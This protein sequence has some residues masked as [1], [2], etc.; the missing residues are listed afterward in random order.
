VKFTRT[1]I[2]YALEK[3]PGFLDISINDIEELLTI[4]EK[5]SHSEDWQST[6]KKPLRAAKYG[7]IKL[8]RGW[9][10]SLIKD[11][12]GIEILLSGAFSFLGVAALGGLTAL[13]PGHLFII[14]SFGASAVLLFGAPRS[15]L[16]QPRNLIGGH[17]ISAAIGVSVHLY[18]HYPMWLLGAL[19]VS[20]SVMAMHLTKTLHP[21]GGATALIA[22]IGGQKIYDLHYMYL[23]S[24]VLISI[25][26]LLI[27]ALITNNSVRSRKYP[28]FW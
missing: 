3:M 5:Q 2:Q 7:M 25:L 27:I 17:L 26:T 13:E 1:Q 6:L 8:K 14:G 18:I 10:T 15:P 11:V 28:E 4:L 23:V 19:A 9:G 12:K 20:L 21:P 16:A 24:P 22:V